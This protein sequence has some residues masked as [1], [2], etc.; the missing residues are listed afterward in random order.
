M[1][2]AIRFLQQILKGPRAQVF[3]QFL[4]ERFA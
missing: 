3:V 2:T 4:M 1:M